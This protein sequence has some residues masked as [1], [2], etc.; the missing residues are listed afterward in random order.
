MNAL[1][2]VSLPSARTAAFKSNFIANRSGVLSEINSD[3]I[4]TG[5]FGDSDR[6]P[7]TNEIIQ[8]VEFKAKNIASNKI[9]TVLLS[10]ELFLFPKIREQV[11]K[12]MPGYN[13]SAIVFKYPLA[14]MK[15]ESKMLKSFMESHLTDW[16][17]QFNALPTFEEGFSNIY[18][19][20]D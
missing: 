17:E 19:K 4:L 5:L 7:L 3:D 6:H 15:L 12:W 8:L 13:H 18:I 2:V 16:L 14:D 1:T 11:I 10:G 20:E 9:P